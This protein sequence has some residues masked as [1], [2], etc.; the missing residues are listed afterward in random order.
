MLCYLILLRHSLLMLLHQWDRGSATVPS[1]PCSAKSPLPAA[2]CCV[3]LPLPLILFMFPMLQGPS[4][5]TLLT[6]H[7]YLAC[8]IYRHAYT[9]MFFFSYISLTVNISGSLEI[10]SNSYSIM[11]ILIN[12]IYNPRKTAEYAAAGSPG[13]HRN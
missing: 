2:I 10:Y 4:L 5:T 1:L 13:A 11:V 8:Q 6:L 7:L 3:P 9:Y 12:K